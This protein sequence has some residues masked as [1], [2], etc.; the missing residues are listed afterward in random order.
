MTKNIEERNW[1]RDSKRYLEGEGV[2]RNKTSLHASEK[3]TDQ[4]R[5]SK[6]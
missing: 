6:R 3:E 4:E 5:E 2:N 1:Q